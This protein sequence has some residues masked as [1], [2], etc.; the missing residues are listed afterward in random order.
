MGGSVDRS[1]FCCC[2]GMASGGPGKLPPTCGRRFF[3]VL[4]DRCLRWV[5]ITFAAVSM[6]AS[7]DFRHSAFGSFRRRKEDVSTLVKG[8]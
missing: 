4:K 8:L 7:W 1:V 3:L 2:E 6:R 5:S